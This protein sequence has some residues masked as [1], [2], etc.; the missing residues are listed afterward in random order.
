MFFRCACKRQAKRHG[1]R[2]PARL[3]VLDEYDEHAH[4]ARNITITDAFEE[5]VSAPYFNTAFLSGEV[6][7]MVTLRG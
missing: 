7:E 5:I 6:S 4:K 3:D 2:K 1:K